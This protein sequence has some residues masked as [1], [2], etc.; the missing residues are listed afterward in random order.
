M[1]LVDL[2]LRCDAYDHL[3]ERYG[4]SHLLRWGSIEDTP[5]QCANHFPVVRLL[6]D[7]LRMAF[8]LS[9]MA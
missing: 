4:L 6:V 2:P 9:E 1:S 7:E 3:K 5:I 8:D